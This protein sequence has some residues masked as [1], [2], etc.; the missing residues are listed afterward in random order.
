MIDKAGTRLPHLLCRR[1]FLGSLA[2]ALPRIATAQD[3][4]QARISNQDLTVTFYLPDRNKGYYRST[5][6]DWS[7]VI[8]SLKYQGHDFYGPWFD[9]RDPS[10]RDFVHKDGE[11]VAGPYSGITGPVNEFQR[12]VGFDE[13][14]P[15]QNFLKIGV[16]SLR[17]PDEKPYSPYGPYEVAEPGSWTVDTRKDSIEFVHRLSDATSGYAYEYRKT[18][19]LTA[20]KAELVMEQELK[21]TGRLPIA[22]SVYNHNFLVLDKA[23]PGPDFEITTPFAITSDRPADSKAAEIRG[24]KIAYLKPIENQERVSFPIQGFGTSAKDHDFRIENR[25]AGVGMRIVGDRPLAR[26]Q[27]WSIRS[28]LAVE[29]FLDLAVEPGQSFDW[30]STYTYYVLPKR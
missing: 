7:G 11:I 8:A 22:T 18:I 12:P 9:R 25:A 2:L 30:K 26:V 3:Y 13:A 24:N 29:P 23:L 5:R 27:L 6:F 17:K 14:K 1:T 28:V 16:G 21:N 4:P 19:R 10:V 20:G 15:G